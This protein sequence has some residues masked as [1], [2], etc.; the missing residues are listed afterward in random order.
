MNS[1]TIKNSKMKKPLIISVIILTILALAA[2][3]LF[4]HKKHENYDFPLNVIE[5]IKYF[6]P[7]HK[8]YAYRAVTLTPTEYT[9]TLFA[10]SLTAKAIYKGDTIGIKI[11][12]T[13]DEIIF[14]SIGTQ[15]DNFVKATA[16]LYDENATEN[17][18]M[19]S[20]ISNSAFWNFEAGF[21]HWNL[22][23][24]HYKTSMT[25]LNGKEAEIYLSI[26]LPEQKV[27][28]G[29]KNNGLS[30]KRFVDVFRNKKEN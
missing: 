19:R 27:T 29:D 22:T 8:Q 30:K 15:S 5:A 10:Q 16:E 18:A 7:V 24:D 23:E 1:K 26:T 11:E 25:A 28:I 12:R 17:T 14:K 2:I 21:V 9:R 20:K 6:E 13:K 4:T 3:T